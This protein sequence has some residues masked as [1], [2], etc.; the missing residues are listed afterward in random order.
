[1]GDGFVGVCLEWGLLKTICFV[2][3]V[4]SKCDLASKR[5][6]WNNIINCKRGLGDG[7]W[8]VVGDFNAVCCPEERVGVN[9]DEGGTPSTEM[10]EF[11]HFLEKLELVDLPLLGRRFS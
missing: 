8:C 3:N 11:R 10:V 7:R 6:L 5:T 2:V 1:M 4:Y 9:V